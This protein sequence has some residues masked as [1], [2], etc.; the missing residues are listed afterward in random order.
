MQSARAA[1]LSPYLK[2][3]VDG[4]GD[5]ALTVAV[6]LG[7]QSLQA[8]TQVGERPGAMADLVLDEGAQL[9]EGAVVKAHD[10]TVRPG[11]GR[12]P[13]TVAGK[14]TLA[15]RLLLF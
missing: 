13:I 10:P 9:A 5:S 1:N 7:D 3:A 6:D 14:L 12:C 8:R 2:Q 15:R 4:S 11:S